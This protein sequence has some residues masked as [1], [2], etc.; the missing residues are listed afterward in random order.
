MT[1]SYYP[2]YLHSPSCYNKQCIV[3]SASPGVLY[4][5]HNSFLSSESSSEL[6][7]TGG[8]VE[9]EFAA[10]LVLQIDLFH[11]ECCCAT[12]VRQVREKA[13]C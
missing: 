3:S 11:L 7:G 10:D 6:D 2:T 9:S 4:N 5:N 12:I 8:R 1:K 13:S